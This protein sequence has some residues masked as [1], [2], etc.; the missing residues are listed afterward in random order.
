MARD[1]LGPYIVQQ[2]L[3]APA[4]APAK[5]QSQPKTT[6]SRRPRVLFLSSCVHGG[7]VGHSLA[8]Y[9]GHQSPAIEAS[10]VLPERGVIADRFPDDVGVHIMPEFVD[11]VQRGP[12]AL[13]N[14]FDWPPAQYAGGVAAM[15]HACHSVAR[16]ARELRPDVIYANHMIA[17]PIAAY[18]GRRVGIP[19][20]LHARNVHVHPVGKAFYR[21]LASFPTSRLVI[22]NSKA[23]AR[24]YAGTTD[25]EVVP[26][27]VDL[28]TFD[29]DR[30]EPVFRKEFGVPD[31]AIVV[32][33]LGRLVPKKGLDVLIRAFA[34]V[35]RQHPKAVLAIV[36][37]NDGGQFQDM[38]QFYRDLAAEL[39]V[40]DAVVF[41]GFRD[42]VAPYAADFDVN[43][44]P[45]IEPESFGRVLIESMALGVPSITT[46]HGGAVEVVDDGRNG[47]WAEPGSVEDLARA[48]GRLVGDD[49][50]RERFGA[51]GLEDVRR[52]Y[53]SA[54]SS[55]RITELIYR[56]AGLPAPA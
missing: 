12:Y 30:V 31:D 18:A 36:G 42:D 33:Y 47:L 2:P 19:V 56:V 3:D 54:E 13:P 37:G 27:F 20:V 10:V 15:F 44:L 14:R 32:G 39:G 4:M 6:P 48:M 5:P 55:R 45:S 46:A 25:I 40:G 29:V 17:K 52:R 1:L 26:N 50:L 38:E 21:W 51:Q 41:T 24:P 34:R 8:T 35:H 9:L 28:E 53:D 23:S 22:A 43:V 11:R 7:G 16:L 49:A